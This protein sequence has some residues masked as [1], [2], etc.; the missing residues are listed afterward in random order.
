M[1]VFYSD[2]CF[3]SKDDTVY[4]LLQSLNRDLPREMQWL[5]KEFC[6][7]LQNAVQKCMAPLVHFC[8][9]SLNTMHLSPWT[10]PAGDHSVIH[11]DSRH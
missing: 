5:A 4:R 11:S 3:L 8:G 2:L 1:T 9:V 10:A 6:W 7:N